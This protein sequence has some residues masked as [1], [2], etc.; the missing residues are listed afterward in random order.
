MSA[1]AMSQLGCMAPERA[2]ACWQCVHC[3]LMLA[4]RTPSDGHSRHASACRLG[5]RAGR[6]WHSIWLLVIKPCAPKYRVPQA[7]KGKEPVPGIEKQPAH[8]LLLHLLNEPRVIARSWAD[9]NGDNRGI[10][11]MPQH[12]KDAP[13][14]SA[15]HAFAQRAYERFAQDYPVDYFDPRL[16]SAMTGF[17]GRLPPELCTSDK[18]LRAHHASSVATACKTISQR[19]LQVICMHTHSP[20]FV[21]SHA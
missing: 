11:A 7:Q 5:R 12:F 17:N 4:L 6:A 18:D 21:Q 1:A 16:R 20:E 13:A 10:P 3:E 8:E 2:A 19:M 14:G 15:Q 9:Y